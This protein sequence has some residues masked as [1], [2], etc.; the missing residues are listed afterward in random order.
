MRSIFA[1]V[2]LLGLGGC[3]SQVSLIAQD[4]KRYEMKVDQLA[5]KL[6]TTIDGIDYSGTA[7]SDQALAFGTGQTFGARPQFF[8]TTTVV[9][10]NNG[11][12]LLTSASGAYLECN[13]TKSGLTII[14]NCQSNAGRQFVLTTN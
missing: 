9:G 7:V 5:R 6:S 11:K 10:G 1:V 4:A 8:T 13:Y 3:V 2:A 14:G 12:A